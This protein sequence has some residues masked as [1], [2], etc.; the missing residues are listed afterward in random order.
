MAGLAGSN[1]QLEEAWAHVKVLP[2]VVKLKTVASFMGIMLGSLLLMMAV[3]AVSVFLA[4]CTLLK[5][6]TPI[7]K[8]P[9]EYTPSYSLKSELFMQDRKKCVY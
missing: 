9:Q 2:R 4:R 7:L 5:K 6:K 1:G 3:V 8:V